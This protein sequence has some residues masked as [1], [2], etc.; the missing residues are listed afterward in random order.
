METKRY[1]VEAQ[2]Q[3]SD[4][5]KP[6]CHTDDL[7]RAERFAGAMLRSGEI[8]AARVVDQETGQV[9]L[10]KPEVHNPADSEL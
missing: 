9:W 3:G 5:W 2:T 7:Y 6:I 10:V 4:V 8:Q 1:Q